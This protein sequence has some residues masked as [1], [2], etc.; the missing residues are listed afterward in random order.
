MIARAITPPGRVRRFDTRFLSAWKNDVAVEL[1]DGGPTN[2]L[3]ELVWLPI[4]EAKGADIPD[5]TRKVLGDLEKRL[6]GD[7]DLAPGGPAPF[8]RM[9]R[10]R[11]VR[12]LL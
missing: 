4:A 3:E 11:Y 12:E 5:I 7:P 9:V 10:T 2:E 6:A 8:Y 1:P